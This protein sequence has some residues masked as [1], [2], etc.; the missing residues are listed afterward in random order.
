MFVFYSMQVLQI[1]QI[2]SFWVPVPFLLFISNNL[3][4]WWKYCQ[5]HP[6]LARPTPKPEPTLLKLERHRPT[7]YCQ[8]Q[9]FNTPPKFRGGG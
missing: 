6:Y 1:H 3:E 8:F 5:T 4:K 7:P 9:N 2:S